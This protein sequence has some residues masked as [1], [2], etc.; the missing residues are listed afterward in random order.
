MEYSIAETF[1]TFAA[2]T[3]IGGSYTFES[4]MQDKHI[5]QPIDSATMTLP[6]LGRSAICVGRL[7]RD[8]G[9]SPDTYA[10]SVWLLAFDI[11][12]QFEKHGTV[13]EY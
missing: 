7:F 10:D 3:T 13:A 4:D 2:P 9:V 5:L 1:G 12:A 8:G 6:T 11:H